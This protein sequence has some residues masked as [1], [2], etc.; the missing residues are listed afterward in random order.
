MLNL[1][2][3]KVIFAGYATFFM[4]SLTKTTNNRLKDKLKTKSYTTRGG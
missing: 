1:P 2:K 4:I 3:E